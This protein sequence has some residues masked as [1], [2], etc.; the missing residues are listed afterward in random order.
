[1]NINDA[2]FIGYDIE[3]VKKNVTD[4]INDGKDPLIIMNQGFRKQ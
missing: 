3:L 1:M 2:W 4:A